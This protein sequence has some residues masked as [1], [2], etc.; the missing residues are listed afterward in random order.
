MAVRITRAGWR[1]TQRPHHPTRRPRRAGARSAVVV[2]AGLALI[3]SGLVSPA[4]AQTRAGAKGTPHLARTP[5]GDAARTV[6]RGVVVNAGDAAR[7]AVGLPRRASGLARR[8]VD[9][10]ARPSTTAIAPKDRLVRSGA[11]SRTGSTL[12]PTPKIVVDP[13]DPKVTTAFPGITEAGTCSCEPPDPWVA[14]GPTHVVQSTNGMIRI[15]NRLGAQLVRCRPGPCSR[16]RPTGPTRI[17]GSCGTRSTPAGSASSRRSTTPTS[18]RTACVSRC[19][20]RPTRPA[21]GSSTRSRPT[22][23]CRT[24]PGSRPRATRSS[25]RPTTS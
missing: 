19:P 12:A 17:P 22:T 24:T 6:G 16:C 11:A 10:G 21:P 3:L 25:C 18:R 14:V 1:N 20:R 15:S 8:T 5:R 23:S 9:L 2:L 7:T 4:V 13:L